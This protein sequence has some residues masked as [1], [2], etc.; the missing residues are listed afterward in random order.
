MS[1][2][3]LK[4]RKVI[5]HDMCL[6]DGMHA[7]REQMSIE[8]MV[9]IATALDA[10]GVPYIQATHGAGWATPTIPTRQPPGCNARWRR[11]WRS[12]PRPL[13]PRYKPAAPTHAKPAC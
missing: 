13:P 10:A 7:K 12:K 8:Q 4:G 5:V 2:V 3:D 1:E 11:R 6:R 9:S